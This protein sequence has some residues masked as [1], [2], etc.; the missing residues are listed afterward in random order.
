MDLEKI[1]SL[2]KE[3]LL[4]IGEDPNREGL[5][6]TPKR[7]ARYWAEMAEGVQYTND[8][9]ANMF[10]KTFQS[11]GN[12][13]VEVKDIKCFS[14]CEHHLALMYDMSIDIMYIPN[15]K[16]LGLSKFARIC[17]MV[18][19]RLQIQERIGKDIWEIL[20]KILETDKIEVHI[21]SKHSCMN[22]RGARSIDSYTLTKYGS[23]D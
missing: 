20:N 21:K 22:A 17:D 11:E 4:A 12:Q 16:V 5:I 6:E 9:I 15:E 8:E 13:L 19:K 23:I 3:F 2:T 1:E 18:T 10:N 7:V 14:H